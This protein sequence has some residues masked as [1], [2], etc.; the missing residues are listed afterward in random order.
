V[1]RSLLFSLA[2]LFSAPALAGVDGDRDGYSGRDD[3]DDTD[4][5]VYPGATELC[6]GVDNDCDGDT[7]EGFDR[8]GD[9]TPDCGDK[10]ECG[11]DYDGDGIIDEV[12]DSDGDGICDDEDTEEC[13][14]VDND[15]DREVDEDLPDSDG[16][17]ICDELD[18]EECDDI[19]NDGDGIVDEGC[20]EEPLD[21]GEP[22][23]VDTGAPDGSDHGDEDIPAKDADKGC[24]NGAGVTYGLLPGALVGLALRR[25]RKRLA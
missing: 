3:C 22:D 4:P 6:D 13:D 7:D 10:E 5:S 25:R 14:G 17:G 19:D 11:V 12:L 2:L 18:A 15:G 23:T 20:D 1:T 24:S 16:D 8:D 21:T 9:G